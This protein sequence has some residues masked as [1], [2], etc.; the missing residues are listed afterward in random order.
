[1]TKSSLTHVNPC[2]TNPFLKAYRVKRVGFVPGDP[3]CPDPIITSL[4]MAY[5]LMSELHASET[6]GITFSSPNPR[7]KS[8]FIVVPYDLRPAVEQFIDSAT[9]EP[10]IHVQAGDPSDP[11]Y[12]PFVV[13]RVNAGRSAY[14]PAPAGHKRV[15][16]IDV[17]T[18][19]QAVIHNTD[20]RTE[21]HNFCLN[22][23][24]LDPKVRQLVGEGG[25]GKYEYHITFVDLDHTKNVTWTGIPWFNFRFDGRGGGIPIRIGPPNNKVEDRAL[26]LRLDRAIVRKAN[27]HAFCLHPRAAEC[28]CLVNYRTARAKARSARTGFQPRGRMSA[29]D[30]ASEIAKQRALRL[31]ASRT[32][33]QAAEAL[34]NFHLASAVPSHASSSGPPS[35]SNDRSQGGSEAG[36]RPAPTFRKLSRINKRLATPRFSITFDSSLGFPGEGPNLTFASA[37]IRGS[38]TNNKWY[39]SIKRMRE[40]AIDVIAFQEHNLRAADPAYKTRLQQFHASAKSLDYKLFLAPVRNS[41]VGGTAL[42]VSKTLVEK[43]FTATACYTNANGRFVH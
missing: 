32:A 31:G 23:G 15:R 33:V 21:L 37:N 4:N 43:G 16:W 9:D 39:K 1:M 27:L 6:K 17:S 36:K 38:V 18:G 42:L 5:A 20:T 12:L 14:R 7:P 19:F 25:V 8:G 24:L 29:T 41:A 13:E 40:D 30:H 34:A 28:M 22:L 10:I 2:A 35:V 26:I 3:N 11:V